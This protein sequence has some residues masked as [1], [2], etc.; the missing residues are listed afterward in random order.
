[1]N[2]HRYRFHLGS[3]LLVSWNNQI[4]TNSRQIIS[5]S[6]Q[7]TENTKLKLFSVSMVLARN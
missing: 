3:R 2:I 1:M 6:F 4:G 7:S 5:Q